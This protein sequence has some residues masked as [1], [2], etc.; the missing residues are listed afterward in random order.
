MILYL[1]LVCLAAYTP[2]APDFDHDG[3]VDQSDWGSMQIALG[4][5]HMP[6]SRWDLDMDGSVDQRDVEEFMTWTRKAK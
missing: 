4:E 2:S 5:P 1:L 6:F 3:D